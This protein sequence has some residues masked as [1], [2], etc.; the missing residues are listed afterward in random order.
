[1]MRVGGDV[2]G[3]K[4]G[5]Y[6]EMTK[7]AYDEDFLIPLFSLLA[8]SLP[9][10]LPF[11]PT[12]PPPSPSKHNNPDPPALTLINIIPSIDAAGDGRGAVIVEVVVQLAVADAE[13][14][15][16]EKKR[17]VEE[18]EGVEDVEVELV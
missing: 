4:R 16:L 17:V 1:M 5:L 11:P 10:P 18:G 9:P 12:P 3:G 13:A 2:Q 14:L 7:T 15:G 6:R 8:I